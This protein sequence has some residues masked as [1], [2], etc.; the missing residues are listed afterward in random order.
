MHYFKISFFSGIVLETP[1]SR[2]I[3]CGLDLGLDTYG[4]DFEGSV[5]N[6]FKTV[7]YL[8][9]YLFLCYFSIE[10]MTINHSLLVLVCNA[11]VLIVQGH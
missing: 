11:C 6:I 7:L 2:P 5:S 9:D 4:L 10:K 8:T 3:L 1:V